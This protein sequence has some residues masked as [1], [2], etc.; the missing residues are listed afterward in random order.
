[1]RAKRYIQWGTLLL[2]TLFCLSG[3]TLDQIAA[4]QAEATGLW[5]ELVGG[6]SYGQSFVSSRDNL[7][8]IELGTATFARVNSAP[9]VF[10]L[11]SSPEAST[12]LYCTTLPGPEIEN[13][14]PTSVEFPPLPDSAGKS[15]Y[16]VLESPTGMPG[17][18]ITVYAN[19]Y[20]RYAEGSAY[21]NGQVVAGDLAFTAYSRQSFTLPSVVGDFLSRLGQDLPFLVCYGIVAVGV[22][23]G[24]LL[25][26]RKHQPKNRQ[27]GTPG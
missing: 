11:R 13:E 6:Q 10:C 18:A 24:L 20:D 9:V 5:E 16:F 1:M 19:E 17:N 2:L 26:L 14:R 25:S 12:D 7:S 27:N 23:A 21:R 3:C 22:G 15:Y 4:Q 8:R